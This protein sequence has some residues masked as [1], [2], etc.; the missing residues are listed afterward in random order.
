VAVQALQ[1]VR[2]EYD[3]GRKTDFKRIKVE[4]SIDQDLPPVLC[5]ESEIEQV[6]VYHAGADCGQGAH[7][8]FVQMA[9]HGAGV[10][11]DRVTLIASD[12]AT[13]GNSGSASPSR[14]TSR[15]RRRS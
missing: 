6:I 1:L 8:V 13:S 5:S 7:T 4:T 15:S 12:T 10:S 2:S 14:V 11:P 3:L 9:A